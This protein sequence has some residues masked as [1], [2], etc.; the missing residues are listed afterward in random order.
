VEEGPAGWGGTLFGVGKPSFSDKCD[1]AKLAELY[2]KIGELTVERIF[3]TEAKAMRR[4]A[5]LSMVNRGHPSLSVVRQC[6]LLDLARSSVYYR[7][8]PMA[9]ADLALMRR[10]DEQYL[11][12][13]FIGSRRMVEML[14]RQGIQQI[15]SACS[16]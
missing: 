11:K 12:T 4:P 16:G 9:P 7:P 13:P 6:R 15:A 1:E 10:I 14:E 5:R 8:V 2:A 3:A